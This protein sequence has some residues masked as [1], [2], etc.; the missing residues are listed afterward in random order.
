M[1][2]MRSMYA[3]YLRVALLRLPLLLAV[4][5]ALTWPMRPFWQ[6]EER[7]VHS[8]KSAFSLWL[9]GIGWSL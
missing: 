9:V 1:V 2:D 3:C 7:K 8:P 4:L 5:L 6:V